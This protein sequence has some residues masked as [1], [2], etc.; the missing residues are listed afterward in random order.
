MNLPRLFFP[1]A[2]IKNKVSIELYDGPVLYFFTQC[3]TNINLI[4]VYT[5]VS[6]TMNRFS[7]GTFYTHIYKSIFLLS[8]INMYICLYIDVY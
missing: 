1:A 8:Q 3:E 2:F 6:I 7:I 4:Q 5:N